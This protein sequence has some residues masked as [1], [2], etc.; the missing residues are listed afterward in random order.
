[1]PRAL[2]PGSIVFLVSDFLAFP[3]EDA[4]VDAAARSWDVVPVV[5]QDPIWERS[6]PHIAGVCVPLAD[7]AGNVRP[8]RLSS[9]EACARREANE[10]RFDSILGRLEDLALEPV[11]IESAEPES[12]FEALLLWAEARRNGLAWTG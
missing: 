6:F 11:V 9:A 2:G 10:A 8:V 12:I 1:V 5:A 7:P 4:W 3:A